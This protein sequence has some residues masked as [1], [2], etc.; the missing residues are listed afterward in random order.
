MQ[1][2]SPAFTE[3]E[4]DTEHVAPTRALQQSWVITKIV[5]LLHTSD[6]GTPGPAPETSCVSTAKRGSHGSGGRESPWK[7]TTSKG[8]QAGGT[9]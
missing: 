7:L 9:G 6:H 2:Y 4:K 8:R 3:D 1:I 5:A